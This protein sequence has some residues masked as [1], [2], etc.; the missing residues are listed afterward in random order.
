MLATQDSAT[1]RVYFAISARAPRPRHAEIPE[2]FGWVRVDLGETEMSC[3]GRCVARTIE[4]RHQLANVDL[5]IADTCDNL[6]H[7][8]VGRYLGVRMRIASYR[9]R[10]ALISPNLT[11]QKQTL[12]FSTACL[13][14]GLLYKVWDRS[15]DLSESRFLEW[16]AALQLD[17]MLFVGAKPMR[18]LERVAVQRPNVHAAL[19]A[20]VA[21]GGGAGA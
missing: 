20:A 16:P 18:L 2:P 10:A 5:S 15:L 11:H 17:L 19:N 7:L 4:Q 12:W 13:P 1:L 9:Q 3:L 6:R 21:G 8:V 14:M